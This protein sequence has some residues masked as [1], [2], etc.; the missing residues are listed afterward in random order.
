MA[1]ATFRR[2]ERR[3]RRG[4]DQRPALAPFRRHRPR[5]PAPAPASRRC[6][7]ASS[8]STRVAELHGVEFLDETAACRLGALASHAEIAASEV[9]RARSPRSPMRARSSGHTRP[10]PGRD[11]R[12]P[13]ERLARDGDRRAARLPRCDGNAAL[14][15]GH[16]SGRDRG[17]RQV[18]ARRRRTPDKLLVA[19]DVPAPATGTGSAYLRLEYR[20]RWRSPSWRHRRRDAR[21]VTATS[22]PAA[23]R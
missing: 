11:R 22:R 5:R 19:V 23:S 7:T 14:V 3:R 17:S 20:R 13:D 21:T 18:A 9:V 4:R 2:H 8:R 6:P 1:L 12:R 15:F 16:P 10:A